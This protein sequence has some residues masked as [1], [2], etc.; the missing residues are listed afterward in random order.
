MSTRIQASTRDLEGP[1]LE[2]TDV[3][4][5]FRTPRGLVRAVDGVSF[6]LERGKALG[7]VGESG[8]GKTILSRSIMGLLPPRGTVRG[9]SIKFEGREIGNLDRKAMR[10][11]WGKEMAMIFQD[12]MT[13]LNP[14]MKIGKQIAEP[15]QIHLGMNK[16]LAWATAERLLQDVRIPEAKRRLDQY[17][18]EMS[19]GMRQRVMI[20]IALACGP[21]ALFA[22]EPTTALDVTVQAQILD[23]LGEQ[24]RDRNMSLILVTHDLGVVA[25]H[26]DEI[27]VMYGGKLVEKAST[28][29]LFANMKMPYTEALL[30]SIPKLDDP[31]HTRLNAIAGRPPDLVNPP[32]GCRFAPRCPYA[33]DKCINE[34]PPLVPT[35]EDPNHLYACW[36]PVGS[37]EYHEAKRRLAEPTD[38]LATA[39]AAL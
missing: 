7:I 25:G 18:H 11:V 4:T 16:Q 26:T 24:R 37:T 31:S 3:S 38:G 6:T 15:L 9:G 17:P 35:A 29:G 1:L 32:K 27:A 2:L 20:A 28:K 13:S 12:P 23:L 30:Q 39:T 22:D 10:G 5:H 19:G 36:Y 14:V 34:E 21:T 8:S 33:S